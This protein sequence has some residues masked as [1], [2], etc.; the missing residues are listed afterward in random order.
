MKNSQDQAFQIFGELAK[1]HSI[2][3][4][5]VNK[6][7]F[8]EKQ[9][10]IIFELIQNADNAQAANATFELYNDKLIFRHD[11]KRHFT[12]SDPTTEDD[13][14]TNDKLGFFIGCLFFFFFL[15]DHANIY[16]LKVIM[17]TFIC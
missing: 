7:S 1:L 10:N 11:G 15:S 17:Q 3:A 4:N 13:D 2:K 5:T 16:L 9:T 14:Y 12:I 8:Q 6:A